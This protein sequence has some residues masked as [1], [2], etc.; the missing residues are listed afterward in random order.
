MRAPS[1][2][3]SNK[4]PNAIRAFS[5]LVFFL[6]LFFGVGALPA[7]S[8]DDQLLKK[9]YGEV[10]PSQDEL[11]LLTLIVDDRTIG[12][13]EVLYTGNRYYLPRDRLESVLL[14]FVNPGFHS[15]AFNFKL[16]KYRWIGIQQLTDSGF[17]ASE[18]PNSLSFHI[19]IP[20]AK[21]PVSDIKIS[22]TVL[23]NIKPILLPSQFSAILNSEIQAGLD[24]SV[25][26]PLLFPLTWIMDSSFNISD[27]V[28]EATG[29]IS[30]YRQNLSAD[31]Q[32]LRLVRDIGSL[33]A[34]LYG[35]MVSTTSLGYQQSSS[36]YGIT[37]DSYNFVPGRRTANTPVSR[38]VLEEKSIIRI[39]LNGT[40]LLTL[41]LNPGSY[42]VGQF[43]FAPGINDFIIEIAAPGKKVQRIHAV[44]SREDTLLGKDMVEFS[45]S[46]G[47]GRT[48]LSEVFFSGFY[49]KGFSDVL[50][51]GV[52]FQVGKY[53]SLAGFSGAFASPIGALSLSEGTVL[54]YG[55]TRFAHAFNIRYKLAFPGRSY[56]PTFGLDFSI[57]TENF[58]APH[59]GS[60]PGAQDGSYSITAQISSRLP[61]DSY[62]GLSGSYSHSLAAS[63]MDTVTANISL[64]TN[65][66]TGY[67]MLIT[68][69]ISKTGDQPIVANAGIRLNINPRGEN[70]LFAFSQSMDGDN[71]ISLNGS[72]PDLGVDT[73]FQGD[74]ILGIGKTPASVSL[75]ARK[76]TESADFG[77]SMDFQY[78][79]P[80][81]PGLSAQAALSASMSLVYIN[82]TF[83]FTRR[84]SDSFLLFSPPQTLANERIDVRNDSG[85]TRSSIKGSSVVLPITSYRSGL[86]SLNLPESDPDI[87]MKTSTVTVSPRY[88]SG[89]F[90]TTDIVRSHSISATLVDANKIPL[91]YI[92][93]EVYNER[94]ESIASTFTDEN[95]YFELYDLLSGIYTLRW[96][97]ELGVTY[98]EIPEDSPKD[99]TLGT[100]SPS[101]PSEEGIQ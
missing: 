22:E 58:E 18:D 84:V 81:N 37:M 29:R 11:G 100:I 41:D 82:G 94:G 13:I 46:A 9:L 3:R 83:A 33:G 70:R 45:A 51:A 75:S 38:F 62:L 72:V 76:N 53:S 68:G 56:F 57:K 47:L 34:R 25:S 26:D 27:W 92:M 59:I 28:A 36:L 19:V 2:P 93:A 97:L 67:S 5:L 54:T 95:G 6:T 99:L 48:I 101:L 31:L 43:D 32:M 85:Q 87:V 42:D 12:D 17:G 78:G 71:S 8:V 49:R 21:K 61:S 98:F 63:G 4:K 91:G 24:Y 30:F 79:D 1:V 40:V 10:E 90:F 7:Y 77:A 50:T 20:P 74:N 80:D 66:R 86:A 15:E 65:L 52:F 35:G 89:I 88:K 14:D 69:G 44:V 64:S 96:P 23:N 60:V 73:S 55:D 16:K 39:V